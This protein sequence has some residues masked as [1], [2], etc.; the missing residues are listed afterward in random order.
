MQAIKQ[1]VRVSRDHEIRIKVPPHIPEN[2]IVEAILIITK[3]P[4]RFDQKIRELKKAM[5]DEL[6]LN[7]LRD[8]SEDFE[9]VD[10]EGWE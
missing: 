2:E 5:K 4:D 7:D 6:F 9:A 8:I 1:I 10:L 3:R